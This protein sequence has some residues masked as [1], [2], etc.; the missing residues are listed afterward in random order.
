MTINDLDSIDLNILTLL[1][2]NGRMAN[3]DVA[4]SVGMAPSAVLDRIRKLESKGVIRG[5]EARL[6]PQAVG[7]GLVAFIFVRT[8][9]RVGAGTTGDLLAAIPEVQEVHHVAGEDCY[10]AK[11]RVDSTEALGRLLRERFGTIDTVTNTRTTIVLETVK[12]SGLLPLKSGKPS[13]S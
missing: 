11:V 13:Q 3:A 12:E 7:L 5:Y 8:D 10:L 6:E 4:R 9:E 2:D 1:Q